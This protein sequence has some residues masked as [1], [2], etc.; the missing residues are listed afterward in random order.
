MIARMSS[1]SAAVGSDHAGAELVE[2]LDRRLVAVQAKLTLELDGGHAWCMARNEVCG[3]EPD[4]Q[5]RA[6]PLHDRAS[7]QRVIPL[8]VAA[9]ENV[10]PVGEAVGFAGFAG[11]AAPSADKPVAPPDGFK[12]TGAIR[13]VTRGVGTRGENSEM[14]DPRGARRRRYDGISFSPLHY[15]L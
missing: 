5:R 12:L 2:D 7:G 6:G 8:T 13:V 9:P 14:A 4:R 15:Q 11:F 1:D 10:P 3:P